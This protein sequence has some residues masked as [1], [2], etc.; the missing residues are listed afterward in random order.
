MKI[1]TAVKMTPMKPTAPCTS[2]PAISTTWIPRFTQI[3]H[4]LP[5]TP[6]SSTSTTA[7]PIR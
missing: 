5:C 7:N 2:Q 6:H 3:A 4:G 1:H